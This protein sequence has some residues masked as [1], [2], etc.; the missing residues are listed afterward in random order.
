MDRLMEMREEINRAMETFLSEEEPPHLYEAVRYLPL[1]GGK[2]LRPIMALLACQAVG[3]DWRRAL[4]YGAALEIIHTFTL[5]HDD[6]MDRDEQRRGMP[7]VHVKF[8]E[9]T[10]ILAGDTLFAKAFEIVAGSPLPAE[11]I[12]RLVHSMAVM[13]KEICEGQQMDM[14]FEE[15]EEVDEHAFLSMIEKKTARLFEYACLGG[16][17]MGGGSPEE[18]EALRHYGRWVGMAFQLWDDCLDVVGTD[19]GKPLGS[20]IREGKKTLIYMYARKHS[21]HTKWISYHGKHDASPAEIQQVIE[22]FAESG[23]LDYATQK[24]R[25]YAEKAQRALSVLPESESKGLL[26]DLAEFAV[27]R[28]T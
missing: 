3:G 21:V 13:S 25:D 5:T 28:G 22:A 19:I 24:A 9:A 1:A 10:A 18:Q 23:A 4:P 27:T 6:I 26:L 11:V 16:A 12:A 7:S 2:R 20:D 14:H 17:I 15:Q 8:G